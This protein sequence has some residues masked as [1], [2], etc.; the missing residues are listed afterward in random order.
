MKGKERGRK[1]CFFPSEKSL[2][3]WG[4]RALIAVAEDIRTL[5]LSAGLPF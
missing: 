4:G 1:E 2:Q 3:R 5:S